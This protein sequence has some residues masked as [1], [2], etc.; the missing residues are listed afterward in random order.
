MS[1]AAVAP[2]LRVLKLPA[3]DLAP[4]LQ[5]AVISTGLRY[6]PIPDSAQ[7]LARAA[8][9]VT[10][11]AGRLSAGRHRC[12]RDPQA[13]TIACLV[14]IGVQDVVAPE[15]AVEKLRTTRGDLTWGSHCRSRHTDCPDRSPAGH[16]Q[17][18]QGI[19]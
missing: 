8:I 4:G 11:F 3:A 16:W 14:G 2:I 15:T 9:A 18:H 13:I 12:Q 19:L 6:L 5:Q 10:D 7:A 1:A 17:R